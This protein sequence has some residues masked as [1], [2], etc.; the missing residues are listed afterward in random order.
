MSTTAVEPKLV[1]KNEALSS[2][3]ALVVLTVTNVTVYLVL[4]ALSFKD[5]NFDSYFQINNVFFL[6]N[7]TVMV[8]IY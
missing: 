1:E 5:L 8:Q 7:I 2:R 6:I 4:F 3:K